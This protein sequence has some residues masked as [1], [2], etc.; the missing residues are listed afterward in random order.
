MKRGG[1]NKEEW[2]QLQGVIICFIAI[3]FI[4]W[5]FWALLNL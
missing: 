3:G 1:L 4:S 5:A 2:N